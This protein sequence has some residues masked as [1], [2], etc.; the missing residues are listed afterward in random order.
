MTERPDR[1]EAADYY[2]KYI[3][4]VAV[5]PG[6]S[7]SDMLESQVDELLEFFANISEDQSG[8]RYAP[9]KWSLRQVLSHMSDTER[10]FAFRALWFARGFEE[11]LPSFDEGIAAKAAGAD[12]RS[13]KS[14]VDEFRAVRAAS[15][16]LFR[17]LPDDAWMRRGTASGKPFSVRAVAFI[18]AG[19]AAHHAAI[20]RER[21]LMA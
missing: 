13:W 16:A 10:M 2:F 6:R 14:H 5:P 1:T 4:Q 18:I 8:Y 15:L 9:D 21:Y 7:I 3:D 11:P 19:H 20:V 12:A 17:H